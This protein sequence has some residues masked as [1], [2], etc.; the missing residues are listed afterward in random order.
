MPRIKRP[1]YGS[2]STGVVKA[3]ALI[4]TFSYEL[5][6]QHPLHQEYQH[7]LAAIA[8]N[9]RS[10]KPVPAEQIVARLISALNSYAPKG[11]YFG[12]SV[13]DSTDFGYWPYSA[14]AADTLDGLEV[15]E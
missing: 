6:Q 3:S 15:T 11:F 8:T 9:N 14:E 10:P 12:P 7:L 1:N 13:T 2:I 5:R 4:E